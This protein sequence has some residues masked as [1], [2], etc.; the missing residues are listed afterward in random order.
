VLRA[1]GRLVGRGTVSGT[2]EETT[3]R[4]TRRGRAVARRG[5]VVTGR[6]RLPDQ[7]FGFTFSLGYM[8][9]TP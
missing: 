3:V 1:R 6:V 7:T 2:D 5:G 8:R 9:K 4:L